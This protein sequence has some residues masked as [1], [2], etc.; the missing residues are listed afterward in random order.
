MATAPL[1]A[2]LAPTRREVV[3]PHVE[4][5]PTGEGSTLTTPCFNDVVL[6]PLASFVSTTASSCCHSTGMAKLIPATWHQIFIVILLPVA[7]ILT[8]G[9]GSS[10]E[11]KGAGLPRWLGLLYVAL[12]VAQ[13]AMLILEI[14]RLAVA[15]EGVGLLPVSL[16]GMIL[17]VRPPSPQ[18]CRLQCAFQSGWTRICASRVAKSD[19]S[20]SA[21][22][23]TKHPRLLDDARP[24]RS[25]KAR[26]A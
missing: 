7:L 3:D 16:I 17:F 21:T 12:A 20:A 6:V 23:R 11:S 24:L 19:G 4:Q 14:A 2:H 15:K 13:C 10:P 26:S 8:R 9:R 22:V 5:G 25:S 18:P 1:Y